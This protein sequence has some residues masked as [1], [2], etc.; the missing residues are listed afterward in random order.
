[1]KPIYCTGWI[2]VRHLVASASF[3]SDTWYHLR[4]FLVDIH[5]HGEED[6]GKRERGGDRHF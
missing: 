3:H 2:P 4:G 6:R 5:T 1:M